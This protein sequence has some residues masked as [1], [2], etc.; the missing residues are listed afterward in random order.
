VPDIAEC[1]LNP[2]VHIPHKHGGGILPIVIFQSIL[3]FF[4]PKIALF[5]VL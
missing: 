4:T 5:H 1:P 3:T 2:N